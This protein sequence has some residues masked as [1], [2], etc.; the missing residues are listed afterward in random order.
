MLFNLTGK[1]V[2]CFSV[3]GLSSSLEFS[4]HLF[5]CHSLWAE[6]RTGK[7]GSNEDGFVY[8]L[9]LVLFAITFLLNTHMC[10]ALWKEKEGKW[11]DFTFTQIYAKPQLAVGENQGVDLPT[12]SPVHKFINLL[13][14]L[15]L[16]VIVNLVRKQG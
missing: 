5:S 10:G 16:R 4:S 11:E 6:V 9:V 2:K 15:T 1:R 7:N 8:F 13:M 3:L 12:L 14:F